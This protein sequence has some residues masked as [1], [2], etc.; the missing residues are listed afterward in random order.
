MAIHDSLSATWAESVLLWLRLLKLCNVKPH[1]WLLGEESF[2]SLAYLKDHLGMGSWKISQSERASKS[3]S[4]SHRLG[5]IEILGV[6][7][8]PF[9]EMI[10]GIVTVLPE[11]TVCS[12]PSMTWGNW[13]LLDDH[14]MSCKNLY[15]YI[16]LSVQ[17]DFQII[18]ERHLQFSRIKTNEN[19]KVLLFAFQRKLLCITNLSA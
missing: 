2:S 3:V 5:R 10:K 13:T 19:E 17:F 12:R 15:L 14:H 1:A 6:G 4:I 11:Y 16:S 7:G 9:W 18:E 8:I